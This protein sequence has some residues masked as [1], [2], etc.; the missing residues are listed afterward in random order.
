M[1]YYNWYYTTRN[2]RPSDIDN[3]CVVIDP[4]LNYHWSDE[5]CN[6]QAYFICMGGMYKLTILISYTLQCNQSIGY[7]CT[8]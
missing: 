6:A 1:N 4:R 7:Y 3:K 5:N 8:V 2:Y